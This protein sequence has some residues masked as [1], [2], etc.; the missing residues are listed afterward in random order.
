MNRDNL[1]PPLSIGFVFGLICAMI[2]LSIPSGLFHQAVTAIDECEKNLPRSQEC[3]ITAIPK[4]E[5]N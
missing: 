3:V 4:E 1:V 2:I 5:V